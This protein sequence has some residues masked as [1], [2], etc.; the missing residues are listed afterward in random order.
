MKKVIG[1]VRNSEDGLVLVGGLV[2]EKEELVLVF[3]DETLNYEIV[4][5][6]FFCD[7]D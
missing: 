2:P 6:Q 5:P 1:M 4:D 7:L 3:D